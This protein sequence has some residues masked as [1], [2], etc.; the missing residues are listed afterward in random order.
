MM[1]EDF[2]PDEVRWCLTCA[3]H[4]D[5]KCDGCGKQFELRELKCKSNSCHFHPMMIAGIP[6]TM[7]VYQALCESCYWKD[8]KIVYPNEVIPQ[9]A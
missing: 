3:K 7:G 9:M 8:R 4:E 5:G 6:G 1:I 2:A